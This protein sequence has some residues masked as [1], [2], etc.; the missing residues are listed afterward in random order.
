MKFNHL[1]LAIFFSYLITSCL[2]SSLTLIHHPSVTWVKDSSEHFRYFMEKEIWT[3]HRLD[4]IKVRSEAELLHI[5]QILNEKRFPHRIDYFITSDASKHQLLTNLKPSVVD[6]YDTLGEFS[7]YHLWMMEKFASQSYSPLKHH[8]ALL[9]LSNLYGGAPTWLEI[10]FRVYI[11]NHYD[12]YD[13]H[14]LAAYIHR[15]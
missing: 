1:L 8:L 2:P 3:Q 9:T 5:L 12:N 7:Y 15:Q 11:N 13:L 6:N 14:N 4:S 10:G